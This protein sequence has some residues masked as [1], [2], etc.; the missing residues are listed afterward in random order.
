M[1]LSGPFMKASKMPLRANTA[2][3]GIVPLVQAFGDRHQIRLHLEVLGGEARAQAAEAGDDLVENQQDAVL[4]ADRAQL[5]EIAL[6]RHQDAGRA[7]HRLDDHGG[8]GR[9]IVQRHD[10]LELIGQ[11]RAPGGLAAGIGVLREIMRVRQ[12]VD[13]RQAHA[14]LLAVGR[15]ATH[16]DAA[17]AHTMIAA[18][19]AD[20]AHTLPLPAR[21][22]I[23]QRDLERGVDRFR[24]GIGE[25]DMVEIAREHRRQPG[26]EFE[27]QR[28]A[29]LEGRREIHPRR[30]GVDGLH[31]RRA[32]MA[33]ID[34]PQARCA[35]E[36]L[37]AVHRRVVHVLGGD[38]H[39]RIALELPVRRERHPQSFEIVGVAILA[40]R[41][42]HVRAHPSRNPKGRPY[43][44]NRARLTSPWHDFLRAISARRT[45]IMVNIILSTTK[46]RRRPTP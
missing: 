43:H 42:S 5:L 11:M 17:E 24:A 31:D 27:G 28:M 2:P 16:R 41:F 36:H 7:G 35:V 25:E 45:K 19:A 14:E 12:V 21:L 33:G 39:A 37:T 29:H 32:A 9:G 26:G 38:E 1:T 40:R 3:I 30:L 13:K 8:D 10:L 18:R 20:Q 46:Y 22:V 23:G 4:V 6:G 44:A 15:N 34:A